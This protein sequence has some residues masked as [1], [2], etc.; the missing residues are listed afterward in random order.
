MRVR[1]NYGVD[2]PGII[3]TLFALGLASLVVG[4]LVLSGWRWIAYGLGGYFLLGAAGM[5]FYS[6]VLLLIWS[7]W[8]VF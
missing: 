6:K 2:S 4:C 7:N 8:H 1:G 5:L 3:A